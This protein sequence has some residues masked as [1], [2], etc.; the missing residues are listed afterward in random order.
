MSAL[1]R[2]GAVGAASR[3]V[4]IGGAGV[5]TV[6]DARCPWAKGTRASAGSG[7]DGEGA[8]SGVDAGGVPARVVGVPAGAVSCACPAGGVAAVPAGF[9]IAGGAV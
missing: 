5:T 9:G 8:P 4:G 1:A 2:A 6:G 7:A 3:L